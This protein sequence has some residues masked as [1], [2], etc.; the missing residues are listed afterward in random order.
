MGAAKDNL[1]AEAAAGGAEHAETRSVTAPFDW[2]KCM[3]LMF[4]LALFTFHPSH[5]LGASFALYTFR[6]LPDCL[7]GIAREYLGNRLC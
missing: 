5:P 1:T 4:Q 7:L 3:P 2:A 6:L